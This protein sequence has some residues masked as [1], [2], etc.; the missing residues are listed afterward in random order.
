MSGH[1]LRK[2]TGRPGHCALHLPKQSD[3]ELA[4]VEI[5][6][7]VLGAENLTSTVPWSND[8]DSAFALCCACDSLQPPAGT[9]Q[10]KGFWVARTVRCDICGK[11]FSPSYVGAHKRLAHRPPTSAV[12]QI[13]DLFRKLPPIEKKRVLEDLQSIATNSVPPDR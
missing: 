2:I 8:G 5:V 6:R 9:K 1:G 3:R 12:D 13:V 7:R 4:L 10:T 11:L